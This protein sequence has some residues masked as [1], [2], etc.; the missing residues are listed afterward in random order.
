MKRGPRNVLSSK[1]VFTSPWMK[2]TEDRIKNNA[3]TE[4]RWVTAHVWHG[5][6]ILPIDQ[7][8]NIYLIETFLYA[9]GKKTFIAP[10]WGIDAGT[11][12]RDSAI[13][14]LKE[15]TWISA[16]S[17]DYIYSVNPSPAQVNWLVS[18]YIATDLSFGEQSLEPMELHI[19]V[20]RFSIHEALDMV[21]SW[22]IIEPTT[23]ILIY[24]AWMRLQEK[25]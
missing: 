23:C 6:S 3:G 14:E 18:L 24:E 2:V 12:A 7:E 11:S 20:H 5:V 9:C 21:R 22:K 25:S 8:W 15:E 19:T 16:V 17:M 1:E 4:G 13:K 10:G